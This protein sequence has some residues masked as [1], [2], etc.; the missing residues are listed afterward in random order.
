MTSH[1]GLTAVKYV[2][3][4]SVAAVPGIVGTQQTIVILDVN[5]LT[6][7]AIPMLLRSK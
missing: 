1:A 6:A 7:P 2:P 4:G 3:V 5:L